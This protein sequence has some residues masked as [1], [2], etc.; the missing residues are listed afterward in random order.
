MTTTN[1]KATPTTKAA[2]DATP[3]AA[4]MPDPARVIQ[5]ARGIE[6]A[7]RRV[8]TEAT[9]NAKAAKALWEASADALTVHASGAPIDPAIGAMIAELSRMC[10]TSAAAIDANAYAAGLAQT[11]L[12]P[13]DPAPAK[14]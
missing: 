7:A 1:T 4:P 10:A 11:A 6:Y 14:K 12:E 2:P 8:F 13:I 5:S 3:K 9:R